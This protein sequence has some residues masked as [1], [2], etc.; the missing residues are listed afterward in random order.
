V[1][2][3]RYHYPVILRENITIGIISDPDPGIQ[4]SFFAGIL[5]INDPFGDKAGPQKE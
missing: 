2:G 3:Q 1:Q 4:V 5:S